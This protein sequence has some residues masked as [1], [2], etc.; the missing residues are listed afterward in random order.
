MG[1]RYEEAIGVARRKVDRDPVSAA[2]SHTLAV[3]LSLARHLDESIEEGRR[4]I[5]LDPSFAVAY[6]VLGGT[7]ASK[8]M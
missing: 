8:R 1:G 4:T 7:L 5:E 3:Q 6:D 2:L